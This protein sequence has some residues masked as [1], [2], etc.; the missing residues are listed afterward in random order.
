MQMP[1]NSLPYPG[2]PF[3][4]YRYYPTTAYVAEYA[5]PQALELIAESIGAEREDELF[6]NYMISVAPMADRDI[7]TSI[8]D[9]ERK[10]N[11]L[12]Q[13]LY[14][15]ITGRDAPSVPEEPSVEPASYCEGISRA[16]FGELSAVERYRL[17][18]FGLEFLPYRNIMTEIYTDELKHATKWNYL[19]AQNCR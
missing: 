4:T 6:Y 7:I 9:D 8:R 2:Y 12:F 5:L 10:H 1:T 14:W 18:L 15:E 17:I 13:E 19:F 3:V 16:I 11:L